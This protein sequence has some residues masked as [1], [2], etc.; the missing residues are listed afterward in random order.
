MH[1]G[2][3]TDGLGSR[4]AGAFPLG[5]KN[6][7]LAGRGRGG[8]GY[9]AGSVAVDEPTR[10][11]RRSSPP[12]TAT[13]RG[14]PRAMSLPTRPRGDG[15]SRSCRRGRAAVQPQR[16]S[17]PET[18]PGGAAVGDVSAGEAPGEEDEREPSLVAADEATGGIAAE[19]VASVHATGGHAVGSEG[20]SLCTR[21]LGGERGER[22]PLPASADEAT[23][24]LR[25]T[26]LCG[27]VGGGRMEG[28]HLGR[29]H[30]T[31]AVVPACIWWYGTTAW[32]VAVED[33]CG[34][35]RCGRGRGR[36]EE[37]LGVVTA[38]EGTERPRWTS[39]P[40]T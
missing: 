8:G 21:P 40:W 6:K 10:R 4:T 5:I 37:E 15:R 12:V 20:V 30:R 24:W 36:I 22:G 17:P 14:R 33:D 19:D 26:S 27:C 23:E 1:H 11:P 2:G 3:A 9:L 18:W 25:R 32:D 28:H 16:M 34:G 38:D 13:A 31:A 35:C 7:K 29:G 39:P